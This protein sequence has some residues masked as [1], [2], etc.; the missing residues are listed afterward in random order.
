M[1]RKIYKVA[2]A[3]GHGP[4]RECLVHLLFQWGYQV[5]LTTSNTK[6]LIN[7]K[8]EMAQ[9]DIC[10]LDINM[11]LRDELES[12]KMIK[13]R[14]P[15]IKI[16]ILTMNIAPSVAHKFKDLADAI[17]NKV[18]S[19]WDIKSALEQLIEKADSISSLNIT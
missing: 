11:S 2:I 7:Q 19:I 16:M 18:G 4:M 3:D 1:K 9:P 13:E 10:I 8:T 15:D 5:T 12:C 14:F 6:E 17:V